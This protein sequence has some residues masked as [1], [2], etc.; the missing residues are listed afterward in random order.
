MNSLTHKLEDMITEGGSG[1]LW[2]SK[3]GAVR[4]EDK[5]LWGYIRGQ[6]MGTHL[7]KKEK[8]KGNKMVQ[9]SYHLL[10]DLANK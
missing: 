10:F 2:M 9:D 1:G 6:L 4:S 5:L 7:S 3:F 8:D